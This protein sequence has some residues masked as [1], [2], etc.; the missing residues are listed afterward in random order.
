[1]STTQAQILAIEPGSIRVSVVEQSAC[2]GCRSKSACG[3]GT[4]REIPVD[5]QTLKTLQIG[6]PVELILPTSVTLG[7]ATLLYLPPALGFFAG[8]VIGNLFFSGDAIALVGGV[9]GLILGFALTWAINRLKQ[10]QKTITIG[11][12]S[13]RN[14]G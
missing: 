10:M 3:V 5:E 13:R 2:G 12:V 4:V 11:V 14:A 6:D 8:M 9:L 1:M 7:L